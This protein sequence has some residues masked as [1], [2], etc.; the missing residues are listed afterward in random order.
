MSAA[1]APLLDRLARRLSPDAPAVADA[2]ERWAYALRDAVDAVAPDW[3]V[4]HRDDAL[5]AGAIAAQLAA[6]ADPMDLDPA[7]VPAVAATLDCA[8]TLASLYP[9]RVVA[10][11]LTG[12]VRLRDAVAEALGDD[13]AA[14]DRDDLLADC[15]DA[16]ARLAAAYAER[17]V[18]RIVVWEGEPSPAA[19]PAPAAAHEPLL[20][21]LEL[22]GVEAVLCGGSDLAPARYAGHACAGGGSGAALLD[23]CAFEPARA[24]R[25]GDA[26]AAA[27]SAAGPAGVVL[28]D[29]PLSPDTD[30]AALRAARA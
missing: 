5:E 11:S 22:L 1:F 8:G 28:S 15:G 9:D 27:A 16:L 18:T 19:A 20:R 24:A 12:P 3:I 4:T 25:A 6:G 17:G 21:R 26:L 30:L 7:A 13:G 14:L 2:P 23:P 10:A 29:G